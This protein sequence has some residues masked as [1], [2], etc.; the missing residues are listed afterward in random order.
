MRVPQHIKAASGTQVKT[1]QMPATARNP[2]VV[3]SRGGQA[4]CVVTAGS[5]PAVGSGRQGRELPPA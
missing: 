5:R 3:H 2:G 4:Q 1:L